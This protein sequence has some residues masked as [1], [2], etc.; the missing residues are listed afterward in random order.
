MLYAYIYIYIHMCVCTSMY[1][2]IYIYSFHVA[3]LS[4]HGPSFPRL[5]GAL[6]R[7][8]GY[9]MNNKLTE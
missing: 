8:E 7:S 1:V 4:N 6:P 3:G 5:R 9:D 2:C